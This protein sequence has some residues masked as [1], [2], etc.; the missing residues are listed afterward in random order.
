MSSAQP[1]AILSSERDYAAVGHKTMSDLTEAQTRQLLIDWNNTAAEYPRDRCVHEVF[2]K[3][4]LRTPETIAVEDGERRLPYHEL[5]SR[6]D[7][8]SQRLRTLGVHED[9]FVGLCVERSIGMIVAM[10]GILKA[11]GACVPLDPMYPTERLSFMLEDTKTPVLVTE[12]KFMDRFPSWSAKVIFLDDPRTE[13]V[14]TTLPRTNPRPMSLA[15]VFYTSGSE[16]R[17]KGVCIPHRAINRLVCNTNFVQ[18]V[19]SDCVAQVS[20]ASFDGATFE[21]WGALLN[22]ACLVII[23]RDTMLSPR[24]LAEQILQRN[25][26]TMFLTTSFFNQLVLQAPSM[27]RTLKHLVIG[28]ETVDPKSV[29]TVL[30]SQPPQRLLNGY[31]PTEATTFATWYEMKDIP[32]D[33]ETIPIGRPLANTKVYILDK[34]LQPVPIGVAGELHIGDDALARGYWNRPELTA[35]KFIANPFT[36]EPGGRLYKTGDL[37]RYRADGNIEFLGRVDQQVKV[38]GYRIELGEIEAALARHESVRIAVVVVQQESPTDQRIVAYVVPEGADVPTAGELRAFLLQKLPEYMVPSAFVAVRDFPLT[39]NGKVDR[40][41]LPSADQVLSPPQPSVVGPRTPLELALAK[42]WCELLK[43]SNVGVYDNFFELGGHSLLATQLISR[44]RREFNVELPL[45]NVF[46]RPT[47]ESLALSI[48]ENQ[49]RTMNSAEL[50]K[51]L[52]EIESLSDESAASLLLEAGRNALDVPPGEEGPT[53]QQTISIFRCP[54][55]KSEFFGR[56]ACNLIILIHED[57]EGE[58]FERM[59]HL[60]REVDPTID[61]RVVRDCDAS[62]LVLPQR[63][64]LTFSPSA[65]RHY[66]PQS[67]RVF[68]GYPL[69]KSEECEALD[70]AGIAIPKWVLL[71]E[72]ETPDLSDFDGYVVRKPNYGGR[73]E[74]VRL[75]RKERVRWKPVTTHAAGT[76]DSV[77]I[78]QFIYTGSLPTSYRVCTLFGRALYSIK[79]QAGA[80]H[81]RLTTPADVASALKQERF[82]I[83]AN[84]RDGRTELNFD[85]EIIRLGERAHAAFPDIPLLGFDIVREVPSGSLYV[86]EANAIGYVWNFRSQQLADYGYSFEEQFDGIR[87]AAYILAENTQL[88]AC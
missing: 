14:E 26:T 19:S 81:P 28:G 5:N 27:F 29:R 66:P 11:G 40:K 69:G 25:I 64:T 84:G 60:V 53:R 34:Q 33:T 45:R 4:A 83:S 35:E 21:I 56:R 17:P 59:A 80:D 79:S 10:L 57:F 77:I 85:E 73:S 52:A 41:A 44:I 13:V 43:I 46:E 65:I 42:L 61:A 3:Q 38:R 78:Q 32:E 37:A 24:E 68:C 2:E 75:V 12:R 50:E 76:S 39:P 30:R 22:G 15:Y 87:K 9:V 72:D 82:T 55:T 86:L 51:M 48:L 54:T 20:N 71:T 1:M 70:K 47:I 49:S 7:D 8:L 67:G 63:P 31:G 6:A 88:H 16:G 58:G 36:N 18:I 62:G 23:S 74:E